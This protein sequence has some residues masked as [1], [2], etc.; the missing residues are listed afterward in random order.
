MANT[1]ARLL[2]AASLLVPGVVSYKANV[3]GPLIKEALLSHDLIVGGANQSAPGA[4]P[5]GLNC[6]SRIPSSSPIAKSY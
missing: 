1:M 6:T 4:V 3:F 2:M 5:S